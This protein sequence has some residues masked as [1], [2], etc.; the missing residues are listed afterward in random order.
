MMSEHSSMWQLQRIED[1]ARE[2]ER[3]KTA[4]RGCVATYRQIEEAMSEGVI[5]YF[6]RLAPNKTL[7]EAEAKRLEQILGEGKDDE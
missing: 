5:G 3:L 1:L 4:L 2:N 6:R 7:F